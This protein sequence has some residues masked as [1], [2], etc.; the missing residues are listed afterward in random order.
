MHILVVEDDAA[1]QAGV[2]DVLERAGHRV[3]LS[4]DGL[5]ADA[6]LADAAFDLVVL[7][8]GLPG[9]DGISVLKRLRQRQQSTPV[10]VLSA[11]DRT[12]DRVEGLD[13]GADDYL[14]KPFERTEFEARVRALLRR[15]SGGLSHVGRVSWS[16]ESGQV[17]LDGA[18]LALTRNDASLLHT[19]LQQPGRILTKA[20]LAKRLAP[21]D[22]SASENSVEVYIYRLRKKLTGAGLAIRTVRG[23]G[24]VLEVD[25]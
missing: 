25:I 7:D 6:L 12:S 17:W 4:G 10:L 18:D 21:S 3:E 19:L 16:T 1:L 2:R 15:R 5:H 20:A 8:L 9:M 11:R 24:Y 23:L 14:D 13:A 22:Q